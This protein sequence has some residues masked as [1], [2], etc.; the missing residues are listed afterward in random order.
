M[1]TVTA[2]GVAALNEDSTVS[3]ISNRITS[4]HG[5]TLEY[6]RHHSG[7]YGLEGQGDVGKHARNMANNP[8]AHSEESSK[9]GQNAKEQG[10]EH[11]RKDEPRS[12]E[13]VVVASNSQIHPPSTTCH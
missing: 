3:Y 5:F 12:N 6:S 7:S 8:N 9:E 1:L 11:E 4:Y 10:D 2:E 13:V